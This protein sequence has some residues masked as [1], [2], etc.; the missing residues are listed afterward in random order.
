MLAMPFPPSVLSGYLCQASEGNPFFVAEYLRTA[1][2]GGLIWRDLRG[3]WQ[4]GTADS[5]DAEVD[6]YTSLALPGS[7]RGLLGQRVGRLPPEARML[8]GTAAVVGREAKVG[9]LSE[10]AQLAADV[11]EDALHTLLRAQILEQCSPGTMRFV[12]DK[13]REVAYAELAVE[14]RRAWHGRAA[15][16]LEAQVA[17][18][19]AGALAELAR[20]AEGAGWDERAAD[21]Y[22]QAA[23]AA[24]A[25]FSLKEAERLAAACLRL[26]TDGSRLSIAAR[27]R[28]G[29][30]ILFPMGHVERALGM[31]RRALDQA[32]VL[33]DLAWENRIRSECVT[34]LIHVSELTEAKRELEQVRA[35]SEQAGDAPLL[36]QALASQA[37]I[38]YYEGDI[39]RM[40]ELAEE[41]RPLVGQLG[42]RPNV[43]APFQL[44]AISEWYS[45]NLDG[46]RAAAEEALEL[47]RATGDRLN[48]A[49]SL[50]N[51]S[52]AY[53]SLGRL[54]HAR[55]LVENAVKIFRA[56]GAQALL[57]HALGNLAE[58]ERDAGRPEEARSLWAQA[59]ELLRPTDDR[60]V[61]AAFALDRLNLERCLGADLQH[62]EVRLDE[63][64]K[65]LR[66]IGDELY[67]IGCH[68]AR[69][70]FRLARGLSARDELANA[71]AM[72]ARSGIQPE[73]QNDV[74]AAL[75]RLD[76]ALAAFES[77]Q[78]ELL[79][80]GDHIDDFPENLK[81]WLRKNGH[82]LPAG[83]AGTS[84]E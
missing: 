79:F 21:W 36:F 34:A 71:L 27:Q 38:C 80:R 2:D 11:F 65:T 7:I 12:H 23:E 30:S 48:E 14:D 20:H 81:A 26:C 57:G 68:C 29:A 45:G 41:A 15:R 75:R 4:V 67:E 60:R 66:E 61:Q 18:S 70:H 51:L 3:C 52:I 32:R 44:L 43:S 33:G 42:H 47:C 69:G 31:L 74:A 58:Y 73:S 37:V 84:T 62:L 35:Y 72:A 64:E 40:R 25:V 49:R 77:G 76:R 56:I 55:A 46:A 17:D 24:C 83:D 78:R 54:D 50:T 63:V 53:R 16:A 10:L 22:F 28:L 1:I 59:E 39:Q 82:P 19:D 8:A 6:D 9:L 5:R 13:V